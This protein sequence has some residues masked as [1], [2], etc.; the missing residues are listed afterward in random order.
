MALGARGTSL[1]AA[2]VGKA[3]ERNAQLTELQASK[4]ASG[5]LMQQF[6]L[7]LARSAAQEARAV[8]QGTIQPSAILELMP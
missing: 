7:R 5:A 8:K 1:Y 4:G 3:S 6:A 2:L